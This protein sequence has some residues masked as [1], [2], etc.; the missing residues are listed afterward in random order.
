MS[1]SKDSELTKPVRARRPYD[2][3]LR[4]ERAAETRERIVLAGCELLRKSSIRDWRALT[5]RAV[6]ERAGVNERTVYRYF[7]TERGLRDAVMHRQEEDAGI[8]LAGLQL[9]NIAEVTAR[10]FDH[11]SSYPLERHTP[12]DPT[13]VDANQRRQ[14]SLLEAVAA[15]SPAWDESDRKVAAAAFDVLWSVSS[16]ERL[17]VDWDLSQEQAVAGTAWVINLV[18][19]GIQRGHRPDRPDREKT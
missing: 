3:T 5:I 9:M 18:V 13:L 15:Q 12:L 14:D 10:L 2:T 16:Y 1:A 6:A 17:V 4:R 7:G 8:E 11:L 19:D